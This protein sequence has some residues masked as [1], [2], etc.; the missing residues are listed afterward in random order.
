MIHHGQRSTAIEC[1]STGHPDSMD[2]P[3]DDKFEEIPRD[4]SYV[5]ITPACNEEHHIGQMLASFVAQTVPPQK[6]III[7]DGSCDRTCEIVERYTQQYSFIELVRFPKRE[8]RLPG[9]ENAVGRVLRS[10]DLSGF[11]FFARY[12]ADLVFE[13]DYIARMVTEFQRDE[14]LGIAGGS[15]YIY[16]NGRLE[17]EKAPEY[18]VRGALKMYRMKCFLELGGLQSSI[19]W[20]TID[21]VMAWTKGWRTRSF[22][23]CRVRHLR[24]TGEGIRAGRLY[25]QRG[26]AEYY[27]WSHPLFVFAK[28]AKLALENL[29]LSVPVCFLA[30]FASCYVR[31]VS[32]L[33][34]P[35]FTKERRD[36]QIRR[37]ASM[38]G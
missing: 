23:D 5:V 13:P 6:W 2:L 7:D 11:E 17:V 4:V 18:H 9:G 16:K 15:L 25:W 21:E 36:Q 22:M 38:L 28:A 31:G 32:R 19:G 27:T 33:Q 12:D 26:E 1:P 8:R 14:R 29:S 3:V 30:G 35:A 10:I 37:V 34:D 20:D 24:P